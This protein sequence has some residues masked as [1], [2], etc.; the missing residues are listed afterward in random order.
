MR[1]HALPKRLAATIAAHVLY[2]A[3][4]P[5]VFPWIGYSASAAT[6]IPVVIAAYLFGA[7]HAFLSAA[8]LVIL[9]DFYF[10][11][12]GAP[13]LQV[14]L[15][16]GLGVVLTFVF[17][18]AVSWVGHVQ[19]TLQAREAALLE[20]QQQLQAVISERIVAERELQRAK[21]EAEAAN[22]AKSAFLAHMSHELRTP[23]TAILGYSELIFRWA[24]HSRA[25]EPMADIA[26]IRAAGQQL[27]EQI[28][29][30]LD[31]AKIE[32]GTLDMS[33]WPFDLAD[34]VGE[35]E[36]LG[37]QLMV[38]NGNQLRVVASPDLGSVT[39]DRSRLRQ[40]LV[41]LLSNAAKFTRNGTVTLRVAIE[42]GAGGE[43]VCVVEDTGI[44]IAPE[45]LAALFKPF[46]RVSDRRRHHY[47]GAGLGLALSKQFCM[48]MQGSIEVESNLAVGSR[49]LVRVPAHLQ[50]AHSLTELALPLGGPV[51]AENGP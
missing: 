46:S 44:G 3:F 4:F 20:S 39:Q 15:Q 6:F 25:E 23:L 45:S 51:P 31:M 26:R 16:N 36:A 18:A 32:A 10:Q 34:L 47:E 14:T 29:G 49:F 21:E 37:R 1:R 43:I 9:N 30:V 42:P 24:Q 48:L 7:P 50:P 28:E 27:L 38:V 41:N 33:P 35:L 8:M 19:R 11:W 40:V 13:P 5:L 17:G 22:R 2:A 12:A